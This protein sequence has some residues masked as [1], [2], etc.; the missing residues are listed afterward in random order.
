[1]KV[2]TKATQGIID[3]TSHFLKKGVQLEQPAW[4]NVVLDNPPITDLVKQP[5]NYKS[6]DSAKQ[7]NKT[8]RTNV[9]ETYKTRLTRSELK[10]KN[11]DAFR[12][13]KIKFFEDELRDVFF[14]QHPWELARPKTL[15]ETK[16][17]DNS[18]C[19]WKNMLQLHKPLDGESVVQRTIYILNNETKPD[20]SKYS[21]FEAYDSSRFEY[22]K[23]RMREE[24]ESHVAKEEAIMYG[25]VFPET[26]LAQNVKHEQEYI[27]VW[28]KVAEQQ[29]K[30]LQAGRGSRAPEGSVVEEE[31]E[32]G[33]SIFEGF[34]DDVEPEKL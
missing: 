18:K 17:D 8:T 7:V 33:P 9:H 3:R 2:Q 25:A 23:L 26:N 29:T 27:D 31:S 13:P 15:I 21:L 19:N 11:T 6:E 16:G 20:G 1:M 28:T 30:M 14:R 10:L 24:M 5:K 34:V 12:I 22:Y 4:Y 32:A